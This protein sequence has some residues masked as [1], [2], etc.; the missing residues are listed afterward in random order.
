M[1]RWMRSFLALV[2]MG[3]TGTGAAHAAELGGSPESMR[4]QHEAAVEA[5]YEF[6]Q[7][8]AQVRELVAARRL[9][10]VEPNATMG[11]SRVSFPHARPEVRHFVERLSERFH[12]ATGD[13][14]VVTSLT[15]PQSGQPANA[16]E[17]S[18]HPA[19]MAVDLRVPRDADSR[20]WLEDALLA[21]EAEG[22]I[23]ATR[24]RRPPHFH[25]AII[26]QAYRAYAGELEASEPEP[27]PAIT[28]ASASESGPGAAGHTLAA[29]MVGLVLV[30]RGWSRRN[31]IA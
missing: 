24:E 11:V 16:H 2:A 23:D 15:R 12:E 10:P 9:V 29:M 13:T 3:A 14:L 5:G 18:V 7:T 6:A 22:V 1:K 4:R 20:R 27:A 30:A 21:L 28:A 19:G 25:V 8:P 17:L 26:P 31:G